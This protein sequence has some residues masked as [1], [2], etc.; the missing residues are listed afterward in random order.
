MRATILTMAM[1]MAAVPASAQTCAPPPELAAWSNPVSAKPGDKLAIGVATTVALTSTPHFDPA[2]AKPSAAGS[3]GQRID[4]S[5]VTAAT[6]RVA[7]GAPAWIDVIGNGKPIASTAHAHG[8]RCTGIAK[9]VDFALTPGR[10]SL[11]L[12]GAKQQRMTVLVARLR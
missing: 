10:Y 9:M 11:Q 8:E 12:S 5:I 1:L 6:Y 7:L 4:F 2:P 3:M